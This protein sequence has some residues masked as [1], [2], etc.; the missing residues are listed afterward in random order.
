MPSSKST[1]IS[2]TS[3]QIALL[4]ASLDKS[5]AY[6]GEQLKAAKVPEER[7]FYQTQPEKFCALKKF[8][9]KERGLIADARSSRPVKL[10]L[11]QYLTI[12]GGFG[13]HTLAAA[14]AL[15]D[16]QATATPEEHE[17]FDQ[18]SVL[19]ELLNNHDPR[20]H[21]KSQ[22]EEEDPDTDGDEGSSD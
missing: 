12:S 5:I 16:A 4:E 18:M 9:A 14:I 20:V 17:A 13:A 2:M 10:T 19:C 8:L 7:A 3:A 22:D 21:D 15:K 1:I 11:E 6:M